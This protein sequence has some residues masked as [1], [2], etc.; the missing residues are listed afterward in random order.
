MNPF[1]NFPGRYSKSKRKAAD[2]VSQIVELTKKGPRTMVSIVADTSYHA[3]QG[4]VTC[5]TE[6]GTVNVYGVPYGAV[7]PGMRVLCRQMGG[8]SAIR[9]FVFDGMAPN[10]SGYG[11]SGSFGYLSAIHTLSKGLALTPSNGVP[12]T[13]GITGPYG[14]FWYWFFYVPQLPTTNVT[15][16]QMTAS[17]NVLT[18]NYLISGKLQIISQNGHGYI[19]SAPVSAHNI[20]WCIVQ[21]GLSGSV[22]LIDMVPNYTGIMANADDPVFTGNGTAYQLSLLSNS[23]GSG[24]CPLGTWISKFGFGT[25]W[26]SQ[27]SVG[28]QVLGSGIAGFPTIDGELPTAASQQDIVL[29]YLLLCTDSQGSSTLA[30]SAGAGGLTASITSGGAVQIV[31]P[32]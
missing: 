29:K 31:G 19:T 28:L 2:V 30:D 25:C 13:S 18:C 12:T 8:Q 3:S 21:P 15:L 26:N 6:L 9:S 5:A 7:V 23:D 11:H 27:Y 17:G 4:Y 14:Y 1:N 10:L 24:L 20:H 16:W 32:Y 22:V